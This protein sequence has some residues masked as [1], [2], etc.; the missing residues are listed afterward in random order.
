MDPNGGDF[1]ARGPRLFGVWTL[2]NTRLLLLSGIGSHD[3]ETGK[4]VVG[5]NLT[6]Q[7]TIPAAM[8]FFENR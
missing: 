8:V 6:H 3:P 4:G 7:V 5:R 2:N 1:P